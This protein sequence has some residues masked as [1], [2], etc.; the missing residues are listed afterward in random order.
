MRVGLFHSGR[1]KLVQVTLQTGLYW[2]QS[3]LSSASFLKV[4]GNRTRY[5]KTQECL[6]VVKIP[7]FHWYAHQTLALK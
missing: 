5:G 1:S 6:E 3:I 2:T 4:A 7:V